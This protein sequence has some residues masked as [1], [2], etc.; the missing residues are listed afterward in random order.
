MKPIQ[1][2][3]QGDCLTKY[4]KAGIDDYQGQG[5]QP[6]PVDEISTFIFVNESLSP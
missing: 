6:K 3:S 5:T 1:S 4:G 2:H